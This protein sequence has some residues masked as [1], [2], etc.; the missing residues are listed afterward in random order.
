[1][2]EQFSFTP[3]EKQADFVTST[4][5]FSCFAGGFGSGKT[6]ACCLKSLMLSVNT[7][8]NRGLIGRNTYIELRNTT[9][10]SFFEICPSQYYDPAY[11]GLWKQSENLLRLAN[12]SEILFMHLDTVSEKELLS[13]NL[14]WFFIDQAEEIGERVFQ[15]LQSRLRLNTVPNRY[16]F[17]ACNPEPGNWIYHKFR[18]PVEEG[19][20]DPNY[21]LID[22]TTD[23]NPYLPADYKDTLLESYPEA[24]AKRYVFGRWDAFEGA[25]YPE[26]NRNI[27]VVPP[28]TPP[29]GWEYL[30]ALDHG[31]VN[32]TAALLCG[33]DF[34]GNIYVVD[35]YYSPGVVSQ[36]SK[37]ILKMT[38][39]YDISFWLIDP[40]T[41]AKNR[42]KDGMPWSVIEEY[43]DQGLFFTPA[44]NEKLAGIN[45][46]REFMRLDPKRLNPQT[47]RLGSPRLFIFQNCVNLIEE[48]PS[49]QWKQQR[50]LSDRNAKEV[51]VDFKDHALDALRYM[52][53]S[54]FE[55]PARK[56]RAGSM[57]SFGDRSRLDSMTKSVPES[58]KGDD[59]LGQL[60]GDQLYTPLSTDDYE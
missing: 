24:M 26:F 29:K 38:S 10:R 12:G 37:E 52:I 45:R 30:V 36:H 17:I 8:N 48:F 51:P 58:Y 27:N 4:A 21:F 28:F 20:V 15:I 50:S 18:K 16:G 40:S 49:Y 5:K 19:T 46:V 39:G 2:N 32:P 33:I 41:Q 54:R 60:Y 47:G 55:P 42:E 53:M 6:T 57:L 22:S 11:G 1:M 44:N 3:T 23:D 43:E 14:G 34:D 56:P 31:M 7:P 9:R 35:E 59:V 13:L 25:I